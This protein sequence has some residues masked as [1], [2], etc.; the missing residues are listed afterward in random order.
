MTSY[1]YDTAYTI[2]TEHFTA[3]WT[4]LTPAIVGSV[5]E[6]RFMD[7]EKAA[8]PAGTFAR[9]VMDPVSSP[10]ASLRNGE[11]GQRYENNG[12]IIIQLLVWKA[13]VQA[14]EQQR[15]LGTM[16]QNIFRDPAFPGCF[17]FT[18]IRVNKLTAEADYFRTNVLVDYQFDELT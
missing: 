7:V 15:K 10:Q 11:F 8:I 16:C 5:P 12:I 4:A 14:A 18:N 3:R 2:I 1:T 9:F 6:L 17:I 13:N